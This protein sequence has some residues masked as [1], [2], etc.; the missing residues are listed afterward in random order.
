MECIKLG[1]TTHS[2]THVGL[3]EYKKVDIHKVEPLSCNQTN[4]NDCSVNTV[5]IKS[6]STSELDG[7]RVFLTSNYSVYFTSNLQKL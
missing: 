4:I 7:N 5:D 2:Y 3:M 6:H 1:L